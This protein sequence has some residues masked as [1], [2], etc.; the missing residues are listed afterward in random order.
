MIEEYDMHKKIVILGAGAWGTAIAH[1]LSD[2]G[3]H[4]TLWAHEPDVAQSI[5][6]KHIN[7]RYFPDVTLSEQITATDDLVKALE[8]A[9]WIFEATPVKYLRNVLSEVK[10]KVPSA[11]FAKWVL[12]SKGIEQRT[13]LL[14]SQIFEELFPNVHYA[15]LGGP[16]FAVEV[17]ARLFT[18]TTI[19]S[20]HEILLHDLSQL[21]AN[22]YFR[23]YPSSDPIGV[24]IGGAIKNIIALA[25]GI[26]QGSG[27]GK[28]TQAFLITQGL[29]EMIMLAQYFGGKKE[30]IMGPAGLGDLILTASS[31]LSKNF[32]VG[33]R[34]GQGM[35]LEQ[36][37]AECPVL[38]EG[39]NT[40]QSLHE[41]IMDKHL[42][43]PLCRATYDCIFQGE[44]FNQMLHDIS[45]SMSD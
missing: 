26:A 27:C 37:Q 16:N 38:P 24:Q 19:A 33:K 11:A 2:N 3:Y 25:A 7:T 18:V 29:H 28:N 10:D 12:L 21:L 40:V 22:K 45:S 8:H 30:T 42:V 43:L 15:V 5:T 35:T 34:I 13:N 32:K 14:P 4:V 31:D 17:A 6:K 9:E 44:S 41:M 23:P 20:H 1:L 39:M 36:L